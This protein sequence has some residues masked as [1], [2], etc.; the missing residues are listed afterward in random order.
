MRLQFLVRKHEEAVLTSGKPEK[1]TVWDFNKVVV[2]SVEGVLERCTR[3]FV[4]SAKKSVRSLSSLAKIVPCTARI[5]FR[6]AREAAVK[7]A[8]GS[9]FWISEAYR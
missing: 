6:S 9:E 5:V 3:R 2:G 1:E 8:G 4:R 7:I